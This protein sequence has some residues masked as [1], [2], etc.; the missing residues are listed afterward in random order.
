MTGARLMD[1][2]AGLNRL[3]TALQQAGERGELVPCTVIE[4]AHL[5][6]SE[7]PEEQ[8]AAAHGCVSCPALTACWEYVSA[9]PEPSGVWAGSLPGR[10]RK[11]VLR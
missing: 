5:W 2:L 4:R 8:Q 11:P 7:D 9:H 10:K 6:L 1:R 3:F